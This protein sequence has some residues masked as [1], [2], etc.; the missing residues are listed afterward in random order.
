VARDIVE[1]EQADYVENVFSEELARDPK[2][3]F[4]SHLMT[5]LTQGQWAP[6]IAGVEIPEGTGDVAPWIRG[7]KTLSQKVK[8]QVFGLTDLAA[9]GLNAVPAVAEG[10]IGLTVG[11]ANILL[12]LLGT[13]ADMTKF[14]SMAPAYIKTGARQV[15]DVSNPEAG[16]IVGGLANIATDLGIPEK[17]VTPG[18]VTDKILTKWNELLSNAQYKTL[19]TDIIRKPMYEGNALAIQLVGSVIGKNYSI[20]DVAVQRAAGNMADATTSAATLARGSTRKDMEA[21]LAGSAMFTRAQANVLVNLGKIVNGTGPER[22]VAAST[23]VS[24]IGALGLASTAAG[25]KIDLDPKKDGKWNKD[26]GKVTVFGSDGPLTF[27]VFNQTQV[28]RVAAQSISALANLDEDAF[29]QAWADFLLGRTGPVPSQVLSAATGIGFDP[30]GGYQNPSFFGL[31]EGK[32]EG[33]GQSMSFLERAL[34]AAPIPTNVSSYLMNMEDDDTPSIEATLAGIT[35]FP[36][37]DVDSFKKALMADGIESWD[38]MNVIQK[39]EF[40]TRHPEIEARE[41]DTGV[42]KDLTNEKNAVT[43]KFEA[44][45]LGEQVGTWRNNI[46]KLNN[47]ISGAYKEM[48]V[49]PK[50]QPKEDGVDRWIYD[51][52]QTFTKSYVDESGNPSALLNSEVLEQEQAKFW[53]E[54]PDPEVRKTITKYQLANKTTAAEKLYTEDMARLNGFE[55]TTGQPLTFPDTKEVIDPDMRNLIGQPVPNYF[56]MNRYEWNVIEN[57]DSKE[58]LDRFEQW[59][60]TLNPRLQKAERAELIKLYMNEVETTAPDGQPWN[61]IRRNDILN[62]GKESK[63]SAEWK[64]WK[65]S[66]PELVAWTKPGLYWSTI[67]ALH[68]E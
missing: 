20:N 65:H 10:G 34:R 21:M 46:E 67:Q 23:I 62:Y 35:G 68:E 6:K 44:N 18:R 39:R 43:G 53:A 40:L 27:N 7:G 59:K 8:N 29:Y 30:K 66:Y 36:A 41:G 11:Y 32:G 42:V 22:I 58:Y 49:E 3:A 48:G 56:D 1:R 51:F 25:N 15:Q 33:V 52:N 61:A 14:R 50:E 63:E 4:V 24:F 37:Y 13:G 12:N 31:A 45:E 28:A 54:H 9:I 17:L 26:F 2:S 60:Q 64:M 47:N 16:T 55:P 5:S 19:M 57:D 38:K